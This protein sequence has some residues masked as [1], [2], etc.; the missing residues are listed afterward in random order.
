MTLPDFDNWTPWA[1]RKAIKNCDRP[2]VYLL[3]QFPSPPP[4]SV[5]PVAENI[6]YV[7][8]TCDQSLLGRWYQ[9]GRSAFERKNGHSGGWTFSDRFLASCV[10]EAPPWL[11]VATL[12]VFLDE[13]HQ[14]TY[15]RFIERWLIWEYV[16]KF[17]A[18][19]ICNSK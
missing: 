3:G 19:P 8:E 7:G 16:Q 9:F 14:S 17:G 6:V 11:Y 18:R 10:A 5:D 4:T 13:P 12:P 2:G 1:N 15:I